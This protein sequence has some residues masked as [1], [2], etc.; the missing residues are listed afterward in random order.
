MN[1]T[2]E[3]FR[4]EALEHHAASRHE[5]E[6]LLMIPDWAK[7]SY[8]LL[9]ALV[10]V[11]LIFISAGSVSQHA[12]GPAIIRASERSPVTATR[13][14]T[15]SA[16]HTTQGAK[17]SAGDLLLRLHAAEEQAQLAASQ[18]DFDA[19]LVRMLTDPLDGGARQAVSTLRAQRDLIASRAAEREIRAPIS[20]TIGDVRVRPGQSVTPGDLLVS[21]TA[22]PARFS[23]IAFLP[24]ER[25]PS[26][27][28]GQ[29]LRLEIRGYPY[30]YEDLTIERVDGEV[31][32]A[33]EVRRLLGAEVADAVPVSGP[34]VAVHAALP[35]VSFAAS[36]ETHAYHDGMPAVAR[37]RLGSARIISLLFPASKVFTER[38]P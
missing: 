31:V 11:G 21:I 37:A 17:V 20:G 23:V 19:A 2:S 6:V 27:R 14:G 34:V 15:I 9:L 13:A 25:R 1:D 8:R 35:G 29:P 7:W 12:E 36:G 16:I 10:V 22:G 28:A 24:G 4:K 33:V 32:G 18:R 26:L 30:A 3:I 38:R 5:G